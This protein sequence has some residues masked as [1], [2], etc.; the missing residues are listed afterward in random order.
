M[1]GASRRLGN[2][3]CITITVS[4]YPPGASKWNPIEHRLFSQISNNWAG[5]PLTSIEKILKFISTTKTE[6]GLVVK[7]Y[8]IDELYE[9]GIKVFDTEMAG[10]NIATHET[11]GQWKYTLRPAK[12]VN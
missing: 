11:F 1:G 2:P 10:I 5:E 6:P 9:T 12:N 4:H 8:L 7:S 3:F